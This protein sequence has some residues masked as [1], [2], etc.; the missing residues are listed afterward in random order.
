MAK[1]PAYVKQA[2]DFL[3]GAS[4]T[5]DQ[6]QQ[7]C[8]A[9]LKVNDTSTAREVLAFARQRPDAVEDLAEAAEDKQDWFWIR[10][11]VLTSK[12]PEIETSRRHDHALKLLTSRFGALSSPKLTDGEVLGTAG[13]ICKRKWQDLGQTTDL[14]RAGAFYDRGAL[15][16]LGDDGYCQVNAAFVEDVLASLGDERDRRLARAKQLR[17]ELVAG[18][19]PLSQVDPGSHWWN[20]ASRAEALFGLSRFKEATATISA[21]KDIHPAPWEL[22]TTVRQLAQLARL[23][24]E[25]PLDN[26]EVFEFFDALV[27]GEAAQ[28]YEAV[29]GRVGLA[30]SGGG[31][32]ASFY[33]LGVLARLA[34]LD[35]LRHVSVL[36]CVSGGSIV[37]VCYF[38]LLRELLQRAKK[39]THREYVD[40]VASLIDHFRG[41]VDR[42]LRAKIQPSKA[43]VAWRFIAEGRQGLLDPAHASAV[44][45]EWFY[46]PLAAKLGVAN[47]LCMHDLVF[48]PAGHPTGDDALPFRPG[49]DNW[50]RHDKVPVLV[51]N[52]TT[53]NT[54]HGWQFTPTWMGESPWT[55]HEAADAVPRLDWAWYDVDSGW[56]MKVSR[57]V[58]ASAGVPGIFEPLDLGTKHADGIEV[59]LVDGGVHD[60]QGTVALLASN[61]SVVIV[62]DACGQ[63][64]FEEAG[65]IGVSGLIGYGKRVMDMLMERVRLANF[66]DLASRRRVG[67]LQALMFVHMKAGLDADV[68]PPRH[69]QKSY[70]IERSVLSPSGVR[71]DFQRALAELRT[72]LDDFSE[73]EQMALMACGYQMSTFNARRDLAHVKGLTV[74]DAL[75]TPDTWCFGK[76]HKEITSTSGST[77]D[78]ERLL[79][80]FAKGSKL[81]V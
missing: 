32:R 57:A 81:E 58:A 30:L 8:K 55:V 4:R 36:S 52:A 45:D 35:V 33:H 48:N 65:N 79:E 18:L 69:S 51:V 46:D 76:M 47:G 22:E 26:P 17:E 72:D 40:L 71:K 59:R 12:D 39:P 9:S 61:C 74:K 1:E 10:E 7:I 6:L 78:R 13:G 75:E 19:K 44:L 66:A 60:N 38:M 62:S 42:N 2:R 43:K 31:F 70:T 68:K 20:A 80:A 63:L 25:K 14:K 24:F 23:R 3:S 16:G 56:H 5:V 53:V 34:E 50:L 54:G 67:L 29:M 15:Q 77:P 73:D 21:V 41:A 49:V 37:A 27:P 64:L 28:M 11:A